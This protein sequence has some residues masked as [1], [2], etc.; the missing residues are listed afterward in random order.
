VL[1][2]SG[3]ILV[4]S[5]EKIRA[6][7][8]SM[9]VSQ[10][11]RSLFQAPTNDKLKT[12]LLCLVFLIVI[13]SYTVVRTLKDTFF[14]SIV[15]LNY[16]PL[17]KF[18][19]II[20]LFPGVLIFSKLVD[21]VKRYQLLYIYSIFYGAGGLVIAYFLPHPTIGLPNAIPHAS[22]LF[23]WFIYLFIEGYNPFLVSVFWSFVHSLTSPEESKVNY[24][25]MVAMS[26]VGGMIAA[27]S[28]CWIL[29][30]FS[31]LW[32]PALSEIA[33]HQVLLAGASVILLLVPICIHLLMTKVPRRYLHGYEAA[34]REAVSREGKEK[35]HEH[36]Q[37][38]SRSMRGSL[39]SLANSFRGMFS[40]LMLLLKYPY[41]L[42][43][44]GIVFFW[45]VIN[46]FVSYERLNVG[47][48]TLADRTIG[49]LHQD[50]FIHAGGFIV[51][52]LGTRILVELLGERR[53]LVLVPVLTGVLLS[54]YFMS[55]TSMGAVY[56]L[57][58]LMNFA[59]A[60]PLRERLYTITTK[61]IK[62]KS[63]S[64]IDSF[65]AKLAKGFGSGYNMIMMNLATQAR[66]SF[67]IAFFSLLIS[68]WVVAAH[69][70][71]RA[72]ELSVAKNRVIGVEG[73][74]K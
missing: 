6:M 55:A 18:W 61:E 62:F 60:V 46:S 1:R 47:H 32:S 34:Y 44:F 12:S 11:F 27:L 3:G 69:F 21:V 22:R 64:W 26:K 35:E 42:G 16:I 4:V 31:S 39:R 30:G 74:Q 58:R 33:R 72:F 5:D 19:A 40:G 28:G 71:G 43:M 49:M 57:L 2:A 10:F 15:G 41:V 66:T 37:Q 73:E 63:K 45:E 7:G 51:A 36:Q 70:M 23:G 17:A 14:V 68:I 59:F 53:S 54:C 29:G 38:T 52:V 65:G 56:V 67:G 13:G 9:R 48:Q 8:W 24:P 20:M 50:F 25:I